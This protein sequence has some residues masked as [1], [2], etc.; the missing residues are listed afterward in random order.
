MKSSTQKLLKNFK[1]HQV[2]IMVA[3][4][5]GGYFLYTYSKTK[6]G[7]LDSYS[8]YG[9]SVGTDAGQPGDYQPSSPSDSNSSP[10]NGLSTNQQGLP[11]SC[12]KQNVTDP[13]D[14]LP[15]DSNSEFSQLTPKGSGDLQNVSLLTAG[16]LQGINTVG[17]SLRNANLQLRS[18]PPNPVMDIGPWNNSTI[19][20]DSNRRDME[21]GT[22]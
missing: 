3:V 1:S 16:T 2:L 8:D 19:T 4:L 11:P 14:L 17:T 18:E 20:A 13:R 21:I 5:V 9:G 15:K 10:A 12:V 7:V 22:H 6:G